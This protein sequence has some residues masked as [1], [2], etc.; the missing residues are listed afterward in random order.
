MYVL[1]GFLEGRRPTRDPQLSPV[2]VP[3]TV[4]PATTQPTAEF[5]AAPSPRLLTD[6]PTNL[7]ARARARA[8]ALHGYGWVDQGAGVARI[9]IDQ[10]K[11]LIVERGLPVRADA[12]TDTRL[13]T[14]APAYGE[15]SS[16]RVDHQADH[17]G[18]EAPWFRGAAGAEAPHKPH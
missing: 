15:A 7:G 4:M 11:H 13:G 14:R 9:S 18:P 5:G 1:F 8:R 16:G 10:A 12:V 2:A 6:E 17:E 3:A